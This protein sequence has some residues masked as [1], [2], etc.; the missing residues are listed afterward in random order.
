M[1]NLLSKLTGEQALDV[2]KRLAAAKG[3]VAEAVLA[4]AKRVL[5]AVDVEE[6]ADEVF[7]LL[8]GIP[9]ENCWDRAGSHRDGYTDP[10][11]AAEQ[12]IEEELQPFV[13]QV[14]RYHSMGMARQERDTC[15][16]VILGAYRYDK[17]SDSEFKDWCIDLPAGIAEDL[18][19]EW[20][21]RNRAASARTAMDA[22]IRQRCP[23]WAKG[24]IRVAEDRSPRTTTASAKG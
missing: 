14:E 4:E 3:A 9:V 13:D 22:F 15:M 2:L 21:K 20:R 10:D 7:G 17:E 19:D 8:D 1:K 11:E 6:I 18:L 12:L 24:M 5:A 23:D 16:G